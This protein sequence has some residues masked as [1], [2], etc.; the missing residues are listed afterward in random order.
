MSEF[1]SFVERHRKWSYETFG[2]GRQTLG[3]TRHIEKELEEIRAKPDD[4]SEWIDVMVL[5]LDGYLRHGGTV[6]ALMRDLQA[7]QDTNFA[8]RWPP[9]T[10][11]NTPS[12]HSRSPEDGR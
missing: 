8:R 10:D 12:E 4:L 1:E 6:E 3:L 9:A 11:E 2:G 7:K 5:A